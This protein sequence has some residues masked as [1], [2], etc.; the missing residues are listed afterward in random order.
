MKPT[1]RGFSDSETIDPYVRDGINEVA[2]YTA[3]LGARSIPRKQGYQGR[4]AL[5]G[6]I[7]AGSATVIRLRLS[8]SFL[9]QKANLL[10]SRSTNSFADRLREAMILRVGHA[11]SVSKDAASVMRQAPRRHALSKQFLLLRR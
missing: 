1:T 8:S 3:R 2:W 5:P 11:A 10:A 9:D 4:G 7:G 6:T